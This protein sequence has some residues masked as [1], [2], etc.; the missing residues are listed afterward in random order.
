MKHN[1]KTFLYSGNFH[2]QLAWGR[3][4]NTSVTRSTLCRVTVQYGQCETDIYPSFKSSSFI[5]GTL[6]LPNA[7]QYPLL[8]RQHFL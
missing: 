8:R 2:V 7:K 3:I 4:L 1:F 5:V 6:M